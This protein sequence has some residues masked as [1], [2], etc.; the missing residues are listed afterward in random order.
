MTQILHGTVRG[1][2]IEIEEELGLLDGQAVE[3]K[4]TA[5][6]PRLT[7]NGLQRCAGALAA[8]WSEEDDH[9]LNEI[10]RER[11]TSSRRE[12]PE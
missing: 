5:S 1:R 7:G 2:S 6:K 8:C 9:I 10:H 11:K 12:I 3:V 4:I